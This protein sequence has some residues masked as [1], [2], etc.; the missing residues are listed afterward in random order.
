MPCGDGPRYNSYE[1]VVYRPDPETEAML[2]VVMTF[3]EKNSLIQ[4]MRKE[5]D[6]VEAGIDY[7]MIANWWK[8]HKAIDEA[9]R[10]REKAEREREKAKKD[11]LAKLSDAEKKLL[12][13]K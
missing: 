2:C 9:R 8:H 7:A 11:L 13:I 4:Y 6:W 5:T 3:L 1:R 12:G 10:K